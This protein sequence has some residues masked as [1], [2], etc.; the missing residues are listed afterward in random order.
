[1]GQ[2]QAQETALTGQLPNSPRD[3]IDVYVVDDDLENSNSNR[4][5]IPPP[6]P[7]VSSACL[8]FK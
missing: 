3:G 1:M 4:V 6:A 2:M 5:S 7:F 8:D